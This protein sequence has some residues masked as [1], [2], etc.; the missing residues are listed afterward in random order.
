MKH[1][2]E[3]IVS[4]GVLKSEPLDLSAHDMIYE[5][6]AMQWRYGVP[7]GNGAIG[8]MV[9]GDGQP[10]HLTL[11]H[12]DYFDSRQTVNEHPDNN[13]ATLRR[14][15][16][17]NKRE[18]ICQ[19]STE[20]CHRVE[21]QQ[22]PSKIS[23]GS[24]AIDFPIKR[25][26]QTMRFDLAR[27]CLTV[28]DEQEQTLVEIFSPRELPLVVL[29]AAKGF[30][31]MD[32]VRYIRGKNTPNAERKYDQN[33]CF[34]EHKIADGS[35]GAVAWRIEEA[36]EY[37][38]LLITIC[39]SRETED[40]LKSSVTRL[41]QA[42]ETGWQNLFQRHVEYWNHFWRQSSVHVPDR[43]LESLWFMELYKLAASSRKGYIPP[44]L[45]G[46]WP[47]HGETP[48][49]WGAHANNMNTEMTYWPVY[50]ANHPELL[51]PFHD[52]L[53]DELLPQAKKNTK[54]FYDFDGARFEG[55]AVYKR[56]WVF[57][58][59][60]GCNLWV[61]AGAWW[62][63]HFWWAYS[64]YPDDAFLR[65]KAYPFMREV[66]IFYEKY[67]EEDFNG[68]L[69]VPLTHSPEW[70]EGRPDALC[71]DSTIDLSLIR[72]AADAG[73][74]AAEILGFHQEASRWRDLLAKLAPYPIDDEY[75]LQISPNEKLTQSHRHHSHLVPIFPCGDLN[76]EGTQEDLDIIKKSFEL[77]EKTGT[78]FWFG[79]S[80]PWAACIAARLRKG[81]YAWRM[82]DIYLE[83][84]I[85]PN[86]F[87]LNGDY[88]YQ[89]FSCRHYTPYT[90]E[91]GTAAVAA[92]QEMLLQSWGGI[93]RLFP[94]IPTHWRDC[95]FCDL[96]AEGGILV[97]AEMRNR[98]LVNARFQSEFKT[99]CRVANP[100]D[101]TWILQCPANELILNG[102]SL[103]FNIEPNIEY[104][105]SP[106]KRDDGNEQSCPVK[107]ESN[108]F[109]LK[110]NWMYPPEI[111]D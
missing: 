13:Y 8:T 18:E 105:L 45:Q 60:A 30:F 37:S 35:S 40:P 80:F 59:Y 66:L 41:A 90:N 20:G 89:G 24:L 46:L 2:S 58:L 100:D 74:K 72:F 83:G 47:P 55:G 34:V 19:I 48:P 6:A 109:G 3:S 38:M 25:R 43:R 65:D 106:Q 88:K 67:L 7:L 12:P 28:K 39:H 85:S 87:H 51:E 32:S 102:T 84:F 81:N 103:E 15:F 29:R 54:R 91:A 79:F 33:G 1:F 68:V 70:K 110:K 107:K 61:G 16:D 5:T 86:T 63:Q 50:A 93:I 21:L 42:I 56:G 75:G 49:W 111:Q 71:S 11:D 14:L 4:E 108:V 23:V 10:L 44:N 69:H 92:I 52:W 62:C 73:A 31:K 82:L 96:R 98:R 64:Y 77:L 99:Q 78:G 97:S 104:C 22:P 94:A 17:E 57:T 9:W 26:V 101:E 27:A 36:E 76:I 95:S 53:I